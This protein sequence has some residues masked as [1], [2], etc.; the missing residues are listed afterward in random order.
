MLARNGRFQAF[1]R[2]PMKVTRASF[3]D[4]VHDQA[5]G[6]GRSAVLP[7]IQRLPGAER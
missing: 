6:V 5:A 7:Q 2:R 4:Y 1:I 3:P